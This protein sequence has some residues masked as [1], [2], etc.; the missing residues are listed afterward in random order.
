MSISKLSSET[1]FEIMDVWDESMQEEFIQ[2]EKK[3]MNEDWIQKMIKRNLT[4][5]GYVNI[6][7]SLLWANKLE[8][9]D[10]MVD[11]KLAIYE[12]AF[13]KD[14]KNGIL[15]RFSIQDHTFDYYIERGYDLTNLSA[16]G[17]KWLIKDCII[18]NKYSEVYKIYNL[19]SKKGCNISFEEIMRELGIYD[20]NA[21][22]AF[23]NVK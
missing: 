1:A 2:Q 21:E 15:I 22:T 8:L 7:Y 14:Y 3:K 16:V 12:E 9:A 6:L 18:L 11:S 10:M 20:Y 17:Q 4:K 19:I 23:D 13:V 5:K